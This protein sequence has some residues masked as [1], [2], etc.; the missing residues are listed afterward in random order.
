MCGWRKGKAKPNA[1]S[2]PF[3][4]QVPGLAP[5][6]CRA[7]RGLAQQPLSGGFRTLLNAGKCYNTHPSP[8]PSGS[9]A[10]W[11]LSP[12]PAVPSS[13]FAPVGPTTWLCISCGSLTSSP[14]TA[15]H[16]SCACTMWEGDGL[17]QLLLLLFPLLTPVAPQ[18]PP[19]PIPGPSASPYLYAF[20][21]AIYETLLHLC[22]LGDRAKWQQHGHQRCFEP[23]LLTTAMFS[24]P[25]SKILFSL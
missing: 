22:L 11:R 7:S 8:F 2:S 5:P 17:L 15:L 20:P 24:I 14:W 6:P 9:A 23:L 16:V 25:V 18:F 1:A 21:L 12:L 13:P 3:S 10:A 19:C 4:E